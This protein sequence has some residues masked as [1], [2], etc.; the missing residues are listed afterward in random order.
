[1][2]RLGA[3]IAVCM[4]CH[5]CVLTDFQRVGSDKANSV[6][7]DA[8]PTIP[9]GGLPGATSDCS[10]CIAQQC[11]QLLT[12]CGADCAKLSFPISP[13]TN[14]PTGAT[15][16]LG[17]LKDQCD[18]TCNVTW[19]CVGHYKWPTPAAPFT[20]DLQ[21]SDLISTSQRLSD[22]SVQA[23]Q[24]SDPGCTSGLMAQ[25]TTDLTG[26][27]SLTVPR[28]F[29]GY[30][31]LKGS[32]DYM[33]GIGLWSQPAYWVVNA[34]NQPL[35]S[36]TVADFLASGTDTKVD[37]AKSHLVFQVLNCLPLRLSGNATANAEAED[38]KV[39]FTPPGQDSSQVFYTITGSVIDR[40]RDRTSATGASFGGAFNLPSQNVTI[41]GQH[42]GV[43][44]S[45]AAIQ[46]RPGAVGFLYLLPNP[47]P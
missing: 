22:V 23:C 34:R 31:L 46:M 37:H 33:P 44:V 38:V 26:H 21:V 45:R 29:I 3:A 41:V 15:D 2:T 32:D 27:V 7:Q 14:A 11:M 12:G 4:L 30:F 35:V 25:G 39:S 17:C 8:G 28:G 9:D 1:V 5:A 24:A 36:W 18:D 19:G 20:I 42:N 43:E 10:S 16:F 47:T 13:A 40:T 6:M